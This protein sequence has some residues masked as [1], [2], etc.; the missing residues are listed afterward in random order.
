MKEFYFPIAITWIRIFPIRF[1]DCK[2]FSNIIPPNPLFFHHSRLVQIPLET[3]FIKFIQSFCITALF[4]LE[5]EY[6]LWFLWLG[7]KSFF[8][9]SIFQTFCFSIILVT[10]GLFYISLIFIISV[11]KYRKMNF[12][13]FLFTKKKRNFL[14]SFQFFIFGIGSG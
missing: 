6:L 13:E 2:L 4:T 5:L 10:V 9:I 14:T 8:R 1:L 3:K 12:F 11:V 7:F